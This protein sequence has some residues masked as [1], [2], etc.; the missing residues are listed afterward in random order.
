MFCCFKKK[1]PS[2]PKRPSTLE[3]P[4]TPKG[5]RS[6]QSLALHIDQKI[7]FTSGNMLAAAQQALAQ[8]PGAFHYGPPTPPQSGMPPYPT[9]PRIAN[10]PSAHYTR[11]VQYPLFSLPKKDETSSEPPSPQSIFWHMEV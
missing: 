7:F 6:V 2:F 3:L 1:R 4:L 9:I 5:D 8:A 10:D 11:T